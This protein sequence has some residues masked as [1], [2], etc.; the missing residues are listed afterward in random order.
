MKNYNRI[1][2]IGP[3]GASISVV[4]FFIFCYLKN[5]FKLPQ[6][7]DENRSIHIF[8]FLFLT[9][10]SLVLIF[11]SFKTL[12]P[13]T[14]G[15]SLIANGVYKYFRHPLYAAFLSF[16]N[17]GLAILLNNWI[18]IIWA[19]LLHPIWHI[20]IKREEKMLVNVFPN[21]YPNYCKNTGRFFPKIKL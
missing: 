18:Y 19:I 20:L 1:F 2:G 9:L 3:I 10:V 6:I 12:T 7:F 15:K 13:N 14:R 5:K 8:L 21:D 17:F 4:L 16:F 11:L